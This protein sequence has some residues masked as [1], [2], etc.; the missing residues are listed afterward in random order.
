MNNREIYKIWAPKAMWTDWV[1]P[2]P[3]I[4]FNTCKF[5][6]AITTDIPQVFYVSK[7]EQ[8]AIILDLPGHLAILEGLALA[9]LGWRPIPLYNGTNPQN[10]V[11]GIVDNSEIEA[12]LIFGA[13]E[14]KKLNIEPTAPPVFL[15]DNNR[16]QR[17]K[18][19][20]S[21][22]DNSWDLYGQDFPSGGY[23]LNNGISKIIVRTQKIEKDLQ[24]VLYEFQKDGIKIY[25]TD[26]FFEPCKITVKK[27]SKKV[28]D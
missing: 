3:F 10:G 1:R 7:P 11:L 25:L 24:S 4:A 27:P 14:L 8:S 19:N 6:S 17:F 23:F 22:F 21:V 2:V 5:N 13:T 12:A 9:K 20:V 28:K 16:V 26:G 18:A 15:L